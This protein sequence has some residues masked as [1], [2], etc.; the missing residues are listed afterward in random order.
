M[1]ISEIAVL[2]VIALGTVVFTHRLWRM[3]ARGWRYAVGWS[4]CFFGLVLVASMT[5]HIVEIL[6][7]LALGTTYPGPA[8]RYDFRAY[9]LLLFGVLLGTAG[10]FLFRLGGA[11]GRA[12]G[13]RLAALRAV[14][15]VLLLVVPLIP[16]QAFFAVPLSILGG[17]CLGLILI[18]KDSLSPAQAEPARA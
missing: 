7:R 9:S 3:G 10:L 11:I 6:L 14:V 17:A 2:L 8:F 15:V 12:G 16:I 13:S 5:A 4:L 18:Y 1:S